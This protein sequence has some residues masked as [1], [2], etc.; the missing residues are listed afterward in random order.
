MGEAEDV[1]LGPIDGLQALGQSLPRPLLI[2]NEHLQERA[3]VSCQN[4]GQPMVVHCAQLR[5]HSHQAWLPCIQAQ[6]LSSTCIL[7]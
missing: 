7:K 4:P 3:I 5:Q 2:H 1:W 6:D